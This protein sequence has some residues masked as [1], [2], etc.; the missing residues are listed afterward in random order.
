MHAAAIRV[1]AEHLHAW[2]LLPEGVDVEDTLDK[3]HGQY[4]RR[5]MVHG[6]CTTSASTCTTAPSPPARSTWTPSSSRAWSS[7]SSRACTSRPTT[8]SAPERFRGIGVRIE[9]DVV[10]TE[11]GC[12]N[13]SA[14]MPRTSADVEAWI[15]RVWGA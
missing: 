4:H 14:A 13:L 5:W 11:D 10:V 15:A 12:E 7:P 6:T 2:G 8:C 3:E 9:D 1:I